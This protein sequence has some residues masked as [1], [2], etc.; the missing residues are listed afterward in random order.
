VPH[1]QCIVGTVANLA[2]TTVMP[3]T[4][5]LALASKAA[6][7]VQSA[8]STPVTNVNH[9]GVGVMS[10][11]KDLASRRTRAAMPALMPADAALE[12]GFKVVQSAYQDLASRLGVAW[13]VQINVKIVTETGLGSVTQENAAKVGLIRM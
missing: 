1:A 2:Q 12:M 7:I 5:E 11:M 10:A 6:R 3:A 9:S 8:R 4:A 13:L